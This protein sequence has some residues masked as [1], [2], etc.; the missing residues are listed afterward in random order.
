MKRPSQKSTGR[1]MPDEKTFGQM[2]KEI[3]KKFVEVDKNK[4]RREEDGNK[5]NL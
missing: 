4:K 5:T 1:K 3:S 2:C